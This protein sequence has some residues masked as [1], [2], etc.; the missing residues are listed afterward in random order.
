[1][2]QVETEAKELAFNV[3][4]KEADGIF[5]NQKQSHFVPQQG[6]RE[7]SSRSHPLTSILDFGEIIRA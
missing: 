2:N 3:A 6:Q 7:E 5:N 4:G 1:M